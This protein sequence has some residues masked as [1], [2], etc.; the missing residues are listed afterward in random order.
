MDE[1]MTTFLIHCI[2]RDIECF[3]QTTCFFCIT[4]IC[5]TCGIL[6]RK[7]GQFASHFAMWYRLVRTLLCNVRTVKYWRGIPNAFIFTLHTVLATRIGTCGMQYKNFDRLAT[8]ENH[9]GTWQGLIKRMCLGNLESIQMCSTT[10]LLVYGTVE[11]QVMNSW[12][13]VILMLVTAHHQRDVAQKT[14]AQAAISHQQTRFHLCQPV[15]WP[16]HPS[17]NDLSH[18]HSFWPKSRALIPSLISFMH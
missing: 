17:L 10:T 2:C 13:W 3:C 11:Q 16:Q 18:C 4:H 6:S 9:L 14:T 1:W 15:H 8:F 12:R 5:D 7:G